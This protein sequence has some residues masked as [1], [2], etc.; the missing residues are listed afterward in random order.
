MSDWNWLRHEAA[1]ARAAQWDERPWTLQVLGHTLRVV[2]ADDNDVMLLG[3]CWNESVRLI[4]EFIVAA[5]MDLPDALAEIERL[6]RM[7]DGAQALHAQLGARAQELAIE[8]ARSRA[9]AGREE[10]T[11]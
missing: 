1:K 2:D 3:D 6:N 11:P 5:R 7:L 4:G 8:V 10:H 9:A